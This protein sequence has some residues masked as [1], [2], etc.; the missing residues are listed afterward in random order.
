MVD[1]G[2]ATVFTPD[3]SEQVVETV[4]WA[5]AEGEPL[6]VIGRD[7]KR[8]LER[9]VQLATSLHL[10]RLEGI[11]LPEPEAPEIQAR[12]GTTAR[13]SGVVAQRVSVRVETSGR[14]CIQ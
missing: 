8:D 6:E 14:P 10:S 7:S 9:P 1:S 2:K 3:S 5:A 12:A 13:K 4:A 11:T